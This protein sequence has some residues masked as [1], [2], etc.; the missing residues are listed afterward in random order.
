MKNLMEE[1]K[2]SITWTEQGGVIWTYD[3]VLQF[4]KTQFNLL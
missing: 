3:M 4:L 2:R 1:D